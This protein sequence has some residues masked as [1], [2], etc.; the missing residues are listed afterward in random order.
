[1]D[2]LNHHDWFMRA[3]ESVSTRWRTADQH[4]RAGLI[5]IA[6]DTDEAVSMGLAV[7]PFM[8]ASEL[9]VRHPMGWRCMVR[10]PVE[11]G[12]SWRGCDDADKSQH[13]DATSTWETIRCINSDMPAR[14]A[15]MMYDRWKGSP[16]KVCAGTDDLHKAYWRVPNAEPCNSIIMLYNPRLQRVAMYE[17]PGHSFGLRSSVLNFNRYPAFI[18]H[19]VQRLFNA[20]ICHYF[21]DYLCVE[22]AYLHNTGQLAL[23]FLHQITG[24]PLAPKKHVPM[25]PYV[26]FLGVASDLSTLACGF[27]TFGIK[28]GR[29]E[30]VSGSAQRILLR[31]TVSATQ[32]AS[33]TGKLYFMLSTAFGCVGLAALYS[34]RDGAQTATPGSPAYYA[35]RFAQV[36]SGL[37]KARRYYAS[38]RKASRRPPLYIWSDAY[39]AAWETHE[40]SWRRGAG[41]GFVCY[42]PETKRSWTSYMQTPEYFFQ[43]FVLKKQYVGQ[44]ESLAVL[45]ADI[46]MS[47]LVPGCM[48]DREVLH[49]I[50]N[51]SSLAGM[52]KGYSS[53]P[54]TALILMAFW[55]HASAA[56]AIPKFEWVASALNIAD[57]ASRDKCSEIT[58]VVPNCTIVEMKLPP[59]DM[60]SL[61][62][63]HWPDALHAR[64]STPRP[65]GAQKRA[66]KRARAH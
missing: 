34:L 15:T 37:L 40:G 56:G 49:F 11:Q 28:P 55:L 30:S 60:W 32:A 44:L 19:A 64:Q 23:E 24:L 26:I 45:A 17:V 2:D 10:F 47:S 48:Q 50:D 66:A 41:I 42:D 6:T 58:Q 18:C 65:T 1:M 29:A 25:A 62:F 35:L 14:L 4:M 61:E 33:I 9:D 59:Q 54:D 3:H 8:H 20:V 63:E 13:N 22:P 51:D 53:K 16:H 57:L 12:D 36:A 21:D 39:Y 38:H 7:G 27:V 31:G 43:L 52:Q 5:Q 46:T